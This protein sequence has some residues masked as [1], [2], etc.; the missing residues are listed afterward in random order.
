M[1]IKDRKDNYNR[2]RYL[3]EYQIKK[4]PYYEDEE[5]I[6]D[7]PQIDGT[8]E[9]TQS[10]KNE[11]DINNETPIDVN[12]EDNE[13]FED[14]AVDLLKVH[15]SKIEKLTDYIKDSVNLLNTISQE[16]SILTNQL[17]AFKEETNQR[18]DNLTPPTPL[19]ALNNMVN[20]TTGAQRIEDYWNEYYQ[21]H[22]QKN[23]VNQSLYYNHPDYN[24][25]EKGMNKTVGNI[26]DI[27]QN[28]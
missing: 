18:L 5:N 17:N 22:G 23:A 9:M 4:Q 1:K 25:N 24:K 28:S 15:S 13:T 11:T 8:P 12:I 27:I 7:V 14:S 10:V 3:L 16:T 26:K 20:V 19:E 21:K 6:D 2:F